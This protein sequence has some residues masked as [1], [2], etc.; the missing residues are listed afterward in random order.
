M[1]D[2]VLTTRYT[3][4][5]QP[6]LESAEQFFMQG[7]W[8]CYYIFTD[9]PAAIPRVPLGPGR[10]L[11]VLHIQKYSRWDVLCRLQRHAEMTICAQ[12]QFV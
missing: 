5:V 9:C 12:E 4:F 3:S 8:V 7:Y 6:F 2:G 10:R 1:G 11:S